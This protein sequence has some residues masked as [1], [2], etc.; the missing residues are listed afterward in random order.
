VWRRRY[1]P[2]AQILLPV[3]QDNQSFLQDVVMYFQE[4][5]HAIA[6]LTVIYNVTKQATSMQQQ[7]PAGITWGEQSPVHFQYR[8]YS[9]D[10]MGDF[11]GYVMSENILGSV[12]DP[13][14]GGMTQITVQYT[15]IGMTYWMQD[16]S[17]KLWKQCTPSSIA[18]DIANKYGMRAVT[19]PLG[20]NFETQMQSSQSDWKF[21]ADTVA[22]RVSARLCM[23][24]ASTLFFTQY[25]TPI[26]SANGT[27]PVFTL[28]KQPGVVDTLHSFQGV[29]GDTDPVGGYRVKQVANSTSPSMPSVSYTPSRDTDSIR[30][31]QT[32]TKR[33]TLWP[34]RNYN[35]TQQYLVADSEPLW[36]YATATT[37]GDP[38]CKV[39][40]V[41]ELQGAALTTD[42]QGKWIIRSATHTL[43]Q[44]V[45]NNLLNTYTC[46]LTLG[47]NQPNRLI[48]PGSPLDIGT[49]YGTILV[50]QR[51]RAQYIGSMAAG[52][53]Q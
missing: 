18:R 1:S 17:D 51:W 29:T 45:G 9:G 25:T 16:Q 43:H 23:D 3:Q 37:D 49:D 13:T 11:Y 5:M 7:Y 40:N 42:H 15:V 50:N 22:Q 31:V 38:R 26:P 47:R 28:T 20:V 30:P 36:M 19:E 32:F 44:V 6:E 46:D 52:S 33:Y 39:G 24:G 35:E 34:G 10:V 8:M 48:E 53:G 41:V 27:W 2:T 12:T 4:N 14:Y 21:L